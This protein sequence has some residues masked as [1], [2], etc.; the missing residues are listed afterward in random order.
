MAGGGKRRTQI[1]LFTTGFWG[2]RTQRSFISLAARHYDLVIYAYRHPPELEGMARWRRVPATRLVKPRLSWGTYFA[3]AALMRLPLRVD[4][5]HT[6]APFPLIPGRVDL[7]TVGFCHAAYHDATG[8]EA[9]GNPALWRMAR[10]FTLG[11]ERWRYGDGRVRMLAAMSQGGKRDLERHY[12]GVPVALTPRGVDTERFR[13]DADSRRETRRELG[14]GP[15]E[16][17]AVYVASPDRFKGL[18]ILLEAMALLQRRG[19][20]VPLLLVAGRRHQWAIPLAEDLGVADRIRVLGFRA[21][22]ERIYRVADMLVLPTLYETFCR[23]AHEA[24]ATELPVVAPRGVGG[25]EDIV[26]ANEAGLL[27]ARDP[28]SMAGAIEQ[29]AADP[30]L[31]ARLGREGRRRSLE[32]PPELFAQRTVECY[33]R[34]LAEGDR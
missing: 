33:E 6:W 11:L 22:I 7:A 27:T 3:S 28:E 9:E 26:G 31:R 34:L 14:I 17:V 20:K 19:R 29:L 8:G 21:D 12:P 24:A 15:E 23:V 5:V 10:H 4:L 30:G 18:P 1:A 25:V 16:I 32:Q 2:D 13:P